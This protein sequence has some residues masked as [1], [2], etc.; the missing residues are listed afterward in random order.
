MKRIKE[1]IKQIGFASHNWDI[2]VDLKMVNFFLGQQSG[3]TST[4]ASFA[5]G[6]HVLSRNIGSKEYDLK[7]QK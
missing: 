4:L 3:Y 7:E 6:I 2:C 1:V 5:Y